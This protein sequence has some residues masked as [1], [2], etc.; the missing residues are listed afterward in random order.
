MDCARLTT[1]DTT[2][3]RIL[4]YAD[5]KNLFPFRVQ[6]LVDCSTAMSKTRAGSPPTPL[7]SDTT[8]QSE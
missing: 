2:K 6:M 8:G 7:R 5:Q 4:L 3:I 1:T